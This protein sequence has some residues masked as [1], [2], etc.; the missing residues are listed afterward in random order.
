M[1]PPLGRNLILPLW[2]SSNDS[3]LAPWA[4]CRFF[5]NLSR[6]AE[7]FL[8]KAAWLCSVQIV[9]LK[10]GQAQLM[11]SPMEEWLMRP[12]T[13]RRPSHQP[14]QLL[15]QSPCQC[16]KGLHVTARATRHHKHLIDATLLHKPFIDAP[17]DSLQATKIGFLSNA[18]LPSVQTKT[19]Q[20]SCQQ[21]GRCASSAA[22]R[23]ASGTWDAKKCS[24]RASEHSPRR[25]WDGAF[26]LACPC[27]P[28]CLCPRSF[29]A[30]TTGQFFGNDS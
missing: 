17:A 9:T 25:H 14:A 19:I 30:F 1:F 13:R 6:E 7:C 16:H 18:H 8:T 21:T 3:I 27:L 12:E 29:F 23:H 26:I 20:S 5:P 22:S 24:A 2:T 28:E 10:A 15:G 4:W 11:L